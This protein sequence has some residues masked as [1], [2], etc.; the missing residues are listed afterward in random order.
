M[1]LFG[2]HR[3]NSRQGVRVLMILILG[4][5]LM[6]LGLVIGIASLILMGR[7]E[8]RDDL[9]FCVAIP[10]LLIGSIYALSYAIATM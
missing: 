4:L 5:I 6:S 10:F 1:F 7:G 3:S 2:L 8:N 9:L